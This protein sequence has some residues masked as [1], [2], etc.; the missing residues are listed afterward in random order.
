MKLTRILWVLMIGAASAYLMQAQ[1][2]GLGGAINR[3]KGTVDRAKDKA[4]PATD[5]AEKAVD[6]FASWSPEEEQQV[7]EASAAKMI[8]VFGLVETPKVVDYV[9]LV[10][11]SVAQYAP[12]QVPYR[13]G[14]LETDIIGAFA[15]PGG[16]IFITRAAL[17]GMKNEA[18]LAGALGHEIIH[19][20]ERHLE[21]EIRTSKTSTWAVQE[22]RT[23]RAPGQ[24]LYRQR[25]DALVSDLM[26]MRLSRDKEDGADERGSML[27]AQ[28]G[29]APGGLMNF[30]TTLQAANGKPQAQRALGQ[31]LSTHPPFE[32]RISRLRPWVEKN[33]QAGKTLD[34]RFRAAFE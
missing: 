30:L 32:E 20:S 4:K 16:Y 29:Y 23:V 15:L 10:G 28:A 27:A 1:F 2:G 26:N 18:E 5:R 3:A 14:V 17:D 22:A 11:S 7:G 31:L 12:R 13:F 9:N 25:A 24:E 33:P 19:V 34:A 8:R 6:T 21:S